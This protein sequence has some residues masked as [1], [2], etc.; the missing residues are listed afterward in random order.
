MLFRSGKTELTDSEFERINRELK[1]KD[2]DIINLISGGP[3][4]AANIGEKIGL[5]GR[6]V[7]EHYVRLKGFDLIKTSQGKGSALT[8]KGVKFLKT[9]LDGKERGLI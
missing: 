1:E 5:S 3:Q 9:L 4:S 2:Y 8:I 7:Q 6:A